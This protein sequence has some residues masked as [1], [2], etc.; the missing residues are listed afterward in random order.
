M[1]STLACQG[2]GKRIRFDALLPDLIL[3]KTR[4]DEPYHGHEI[5]NMS[6]GG[7][8]RVELWAC[9]SGVEMDVLG[10]ILGNDEPLGIASCFLLAGAHVVIDSIWKQP[11]IVAAMIAAA[12]AAQ[13]RL[14][15][16]AGTDARALARALAAYRK[17]VAEEGIFETTL[18]AALRDALTQP[19]PRPDPIPHAFHT[20]WCAAVSHLTRKASVDLPWSA[21]EPF[22]AN[23]S[24]LSEARTLTGDPAALDHDLHRVAR[25]LTDELRADSATAWRVLARE[26]VML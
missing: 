18:R 7:C 19:N 9:E 6:L 21:V 8:R 22:Q 25:R 4:E 23:D 2:T 26:R 13:A 24:L 5:L 16:S 1:T 20:A 10:A 11:A 15:G 17:V 14:P 3:G 12:F